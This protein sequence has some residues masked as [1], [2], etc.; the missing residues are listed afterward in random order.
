MDRV[1]YGA[2]RA[3]SAKHVGVAG[4]LDPLFDHFVALART[5]GSRER[6]LA[7]GEAIRAVIRQG[8]ERGCWARV[9]ELA[10]AVEHHLVEGARWGAWE[11]VLDAA[12]VA[13]RALGDRS[14]EGWVLHQKGVRAMALGDPGYARAVLSD[15]L[16]VRCE[17]GEGAPVAAT[18]SQLAVLSS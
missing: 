4:S 5:P 3:F 9:L 11:T 10:R 16:A 7:S 13:A 1:R 17:V 2:T 15:A 12:L 8:L 18:R 14:S 6:I